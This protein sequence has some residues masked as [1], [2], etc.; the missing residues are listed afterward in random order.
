MGGGRVIA[1]IG[2]DVNHGEAI[3]L[4]AAHDAEQVA[5]QAFMAAKVI[6]EHAIL[7]ASRAFKSWQDARENQK[8]L[9]GEC[10]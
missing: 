10:S 6:R 9:G 5:W 1:T 8:R 4:N 2:K 7:D 3:A